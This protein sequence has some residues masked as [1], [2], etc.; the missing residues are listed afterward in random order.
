MKLYTKKPILFHDF[1]EIA[2]IDR[3]KGE[4]RWERG[5]RKG[6]GREGARQ[7]EY[8]THLSTPQYLTAPRHTEMQF[9]G[10]LS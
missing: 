9:L 10:Y 6:G 3:A 4:L 7:R 5:R 2:N 8:A 1:P